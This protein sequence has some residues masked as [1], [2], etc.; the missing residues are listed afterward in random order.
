MFQDIKL[1]ILFQTSRFGRIVWRSSIVKD[2]ASY[3]MADDRSRAL[4]GTMSLSLTS[5]WCSDLGDTRQA[6]YPLGTL[7]NA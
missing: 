4:G 2:D 1:F 3:E 5:E 7:G 6:P